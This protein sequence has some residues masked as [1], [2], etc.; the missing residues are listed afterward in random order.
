L[1]LNMATLNTPLMVMNGFEMHCLDR[2]SEDAFLDILQ[3]LSKR[4][5]PL[6]QDC[7]TDQLQLFGR[8]MYQ[9][10]ILDPVSFVMTTSGAKQVVAL[11]AAWDLRHG[12]LWKSDAVPSA[13]KGHATV[14]AACCAT[15]PT[16]KAL[17]WGMCGVR[18]GQPKE[19]VIPCICYQI[20]CAVRMGFDHR[21]AYVLHPSMLAWAAKEKSIIF[22]ASKWQ[23]PYS[24][25]DAEDD[26]MRGLCDLKPDY[27]TCALQDLRTIRENYDM[28][29][30]TMSPDMRALFEGFDQPVQEHL[31]SR[32]YRVHELGM[33]PTMQLLSA[34]SVS[35]KL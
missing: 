23:L 19:L 24:E 7:P 8:L 29:L 14:A 28:A 22:E 32:D 31:R 15:A 26:V 33:A 20:L 25:M 6:L 21:F 3:D 35:S 30:G 10:A 9:Q 2:I 1:H 18:R 17:Y 5:N 34:V 12:S 16:E 13:L 11:S 4:G 27:A